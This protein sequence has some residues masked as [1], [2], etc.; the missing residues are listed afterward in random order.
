M[1]LFVYYLYGAKLQFLAECYNFFLIKAV[2]ELIR[3][4]IVSRLFCI[5]AFSKSLYTK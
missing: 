5:F 1:L 4:Q 3:I 2:K